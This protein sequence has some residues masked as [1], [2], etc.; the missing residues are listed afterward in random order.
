MDAPPR[1]QPGGAIKK[2]ARRTGKNLRYLHGIVGKLA[3]R[4]DLLEPVP[5]NFDFF[6]FFLGGC[7]G[8]RL[9]CLGR[10]GRRGGNRGRFAN[11]FIPV[12][13]HPLFHFEGVHLRDLVGDFRAPDQIGVLVTRIDPKVS[14]SA[15]GLQVGDVVV[16]LAD[17]LVENSTQFHQLLNVALAEGVEPLALEL[18]RQGNAAEAWF[19]PV[20][21]PVRATATVP[22]ET[23][24]QAIRLEIRRLEIRIK[25]LRG[26]LEQR[27]RDP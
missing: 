11:G 9:Q 23:V 20:A 17:D 22:S 6:F 27:H 4:L 13:I 15:S 3:G 21:P 5:N 2:T 10:Y 14:P 8:L 24:E 18:V 19:E 16:G 7:P 26:Q 25:T 12:D 1:F